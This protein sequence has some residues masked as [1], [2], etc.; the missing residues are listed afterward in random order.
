M[1]KIMVKLKTSGLI[2]CLNHSGIS[3]INYRGK[4]SEFDEHDE[5]VRKRI[6]VMFFDF[7]R[8]TLKMN[9]NEQT[10]IKQLYEFIDEW[11]EKHFLFEFKEEDWNFMPLELKVK[12]KDED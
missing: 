2:G 7:Y 10:S 3:N 9:W 12:I 8:D 11:I 1:S 5:K 6:R 4:M